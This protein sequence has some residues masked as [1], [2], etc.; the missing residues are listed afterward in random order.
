[1]YNP[2]PTLFVGGINEFWIY[3]RALSGVEIREELVGEL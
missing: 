2:D 1:M 3:D